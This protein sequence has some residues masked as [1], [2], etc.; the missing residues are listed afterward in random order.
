MQIHAFCGGIGIPAPLHHAAV[1]LY[2][3][4]VCHFSTLH[5]ILGIAD[6]FAVAVLAAYRSLLDGYAALFQI[7]DAGSKAVDAVLLHGLCS[8]QAA[9]AL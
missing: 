1:Q 6:F 8:G 7:I 4:L 5:V 9:A 2:V 3:T